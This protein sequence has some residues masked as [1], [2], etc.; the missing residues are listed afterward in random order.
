VITI[1]I[2]VVEK[3]AD[4]LVVFLPVLFDR[5]FAKTEFEFLLSFWDLFEF[6]QIV[7]LE[8]FHLLN[9][10]GVLFVFLILFGL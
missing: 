8:L 1:A 5:F 3:A 7:F 2:I 6:F 4:I 9:W 10:L